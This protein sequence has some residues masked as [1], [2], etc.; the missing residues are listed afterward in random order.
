MSF[1]KCV[2]FDG[3]KKFNAETSGG[4]SYFKIEKDAAGNWIINVQLT[5]IREEGEKS[6]DDFVSLNTPEDQIKN[7][8][9]LVYIT[10]KD[11]DSQFMRITPEKGNLIVVYDKSNI[12]EVSLKMEITNTG[13][14]QN[15]KTQNPRVD[16]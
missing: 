8:Q 9:N 13:K 4:A 16:G 15:S 7:L 5:L 6:I 11:N 10:A 12:S 3:G 14:T 1:T 2:F